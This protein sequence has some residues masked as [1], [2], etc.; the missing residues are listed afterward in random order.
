MAAQTRVRQAQANLERQGV[1][2]IPNITA[3]LASGIDNGTNSGMIN[4]QFGAPIPV[5]N[6]NQGNIAAARAEYCRALMEVSRIENAIQARLAAVSNDFD[7]ALA[8]VNKYQTEI[9]PSARETLTLAEQAYKAGEFSFLEVLTVRRT[10]FE[11]NLQM[12]RSQVQLATANAQ[13]S[14]FVL[15]GGLDATV[16]QSG[17]DSL[18]GLTFS[19]Q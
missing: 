12:L 16:D 9:L 17:D 6:K 7:T 5:F 18:R 8:A 19:Q 4:L 2:A 1:Q 10:Y 11:S 14:G 13:V 15:T 3:Q